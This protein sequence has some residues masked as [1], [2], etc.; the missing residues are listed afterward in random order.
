MKTKCNV[1]SWI[2]SWNKRSTLVEKLVKLES[3]LEYKKKK[4][5]ES[6]LEETVM[7][8]ASIYKEVD[9]E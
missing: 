2:G 7:T 1:G 3:C 9:T 8:I 5:N 4:K 6:L